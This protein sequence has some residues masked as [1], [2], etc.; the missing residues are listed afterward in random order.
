VRLHFGEI[1]LF[2]ARRLV[3]AVAALLIA[4]PQLPAKSAP[5]AW[6]KVVSQTK[7]E[8]LGVTETRLA[9]GLM[10][11]SKEDHS[12]PV[13][14]F[15]VWYRVGSRNE[16][17]GHTGVSH[18]LEHMMFK[19]TKTLPTAAV[20]RL[21]TENGAEINASTSYDRTEYHELISADRL[22]LAV[23]LEADR[24]VNSTFDAAELAHETGVVQS[25]LE[26][27]F[28]NPSYELLNNYWYTTA[29]TKHPYRWPVIGS[30]KDIASAASQ[31]DSVYRYYKQHYAPNNAFIV[32]V[33]DFKTSSAVAL[34][35]KY[36][37]AHAPA[38]IESHPIP[39]EPE[40][41]GERRAVLRRPGTTGHV[42]IG[43]HV[44]AT[45]DH[46]HY[47][48]DNLG[49]FFASG[50][51]SRL[52]RA[53]VDTGFANSV[54]V[55]SVD[56]IDPCLFEISVSPQS[57]VSN[58][59]VERIVYDEIAKLQNEPASQSD[60]DRGFASIVGWYRGSQLT[61]SSQA[62]FLGEMEIEASKVG[63]YRYLDMYFRRAR[64]VT[65]EDVQRVA[66]KYLVPE[67]RTV[68][69][70]EPQPMPA[71][72]PVVRPAAAVEESHTPPPVADARQKA[73]IERIIKAYTP[74]ASPS[75]F[76]KRPKPV[77]V[78]LPNGIVVIVEENHA[79]HVVAI[80]G[81]MLA[82]A[83]LDPA[84]KWGAA[85]MTA[86]ML[87]LGTLSMNDLQI[88]AKLEDIGGGVHFG[89]GSEM[90][91]I[92]AA[93]DRAGLA[94]TLGVMSDEMR[95]ATFPAAHVEKQ[96]WRM[97]SA[98]E[99]AKQD[100][101]GAGG[102]GELASIAFSRSIFPKGHP[103]YSPTI[104]EQ[105]DAIRSLTVNDL[106]SFYRANYRP[107][108]LM[109][110]ISGDVNAAT[111]V[112]AVKKALGGWAK[113]ASP[114]P[115]PVAPVV[116]LASEVATRQSIV[117]SGAPQTSIL[118][119]HSLPLQRS[120]KAYYATEILGYILGGSVFDSRL[121]SAIRT[122][123][124]L[125]YTV[126][127]DFS[128]WRGGG[129]FQVFVGA[130]PANAN[131]AIALVDQ[132]V[133]DVHSRGVTQDEVDEAKRY[134]TGSY[135]L[136]LASSIGEA[137]L[138]LDAENYGLG[139]D[140]PDRRNAQIQAVTLADVNAAARRYLAPEKAAVVL[141]GAAVPG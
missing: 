29:Y 99:T 1:T 82:G 139:L 113:P 88:N 39:S 27:R 10:I 91:V 130:N 70:F 37:G 75:P 87:P 26:G 98:L 84:G 40:Q 137:V 56:K 136:M 97:L 14:H 115:S 50:E 21:L 51:N 72:A 44:P 28:S 119:G 77:R 15:S 121:G 46:D 67:N 112:A 23:K 13:A 71:N 18:I 61:V 22:E 69:V 80:C 132:I 111:A 104:D 81:R 32:M 42:L 12:A 68:A 5:P 141:S 36:F 41:L 4:A 76:A 78:V 63:G 6:G 55:A 73:A 30:R 65:G 16:T 9:N 64:A 105:E 118:W 47:A 66:R 108:T 45:G 85:E 48:L 90:A 131:A 79:N 116:D 102:A 120:D 129:M 62:Q 38:K 96:R 83:M 35:A 124:G 127:A 49:N 54:S 94:D 19:G 138:L 114:P 95:N 74:P 93:S 110:V 109:L 59:A 24:M 92:Y 106:R 101:G 17:P 117:L 122:K 2:T 34:C 58:E 126:S 8:W 128:A 86:S 53:L 107:D 103:Y 20:S 31:R 25:E 7:D 100:A 133:G 57:G 33:G 11:L 3:F 135:S 89:A 52:H 125:A 60:I 134:L 123:N 140:Y 43:Y